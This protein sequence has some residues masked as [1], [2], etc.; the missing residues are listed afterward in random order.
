MRLAN[1]VLC[2]ASMLVLFV[3]PVPAQQVYKAGDGVSLPVVVESVHP[4]Y[5]PEARAAGIEGSVTL[6]AVVLPDGRV[7]D[8]DVVRSLDAVLGLDREAVKAMKQW[9]FKPGTKDGTAVA[10]RIEVRVYFALR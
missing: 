8:V 3:A 10:V 9:T 2:V 5:T 6:A 4:D 1:R 7:G